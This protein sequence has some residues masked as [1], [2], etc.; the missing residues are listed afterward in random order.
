MEN[1]KRQSSES[2][3][4]QPER[5]TESKTPSVINP[6]PTDQTSSASSATTGKKPSSVYALIW[7]GIIAAVLGVL[8]HESFDSEKVLFA[9]D[10]PL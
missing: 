1:N 2:Q 3:G 7:I 6:G 8:F 9:N 10:G 4:K 5:E